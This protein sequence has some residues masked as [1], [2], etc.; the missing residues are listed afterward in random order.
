MS[1]FKEY[2]IFNATSITGFR[3]S[4]L[5]VFSKLG[6][7][8][9]CLTASDVI[10]AIS[11]YKFNWYHSVRLRSS[12]RAQK[13]RNYLKR[14]TLGISCW[15]LLKQFRQRTILIGF[16]FNLSLLWSIK[17]NNFLLSSGYSR[18]QFY[19]TIWKEIL[20]LHEKY[21]GKKPLNL[22]ST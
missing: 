5:I 1:I 20:H 16:C 12:G 9:N 21:F 14:N 15:I 2:T 6:G 19:L 18:L 7:K 13:L 3:Q 17:W 8:I 22:R 10:N 4:L 11:V